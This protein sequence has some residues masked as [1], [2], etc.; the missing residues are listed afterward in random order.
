MAGTSSTAW[1][2]VARFVCKVPGAAK[3]V[4]LGY[5]AYTIAVD[6][7]TRRSCLAYQFVPAALL[8]RQ[9]SFTS[10][11]ITLVGAHREDHLLL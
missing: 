11:P 6:D 7:D 1:F 3:H 8:S 10:I 4:T 9:H 5:D 2:G